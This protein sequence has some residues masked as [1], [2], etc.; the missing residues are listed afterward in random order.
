M[1]NDK[2]FYRLLSKHMHDV[3][4]Y[5]YNCKIIMKQLGKCAPNSAVC[6]GFVLLRKSKQKASSSEHVLEVPLKVKEAP[7]VFLL[8]PSDFQ[9]QCHLMIQDGWSSCHS[10]HVTVSKA[11]KIEEK[12]ERRGALLFFKN[13]SRENLIWHSCLYLTFCQ[14][15]VHGHK[16]QRSLGKC[17]N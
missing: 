16:L 7:P 6:Q 14:N 3:P 5:K 10:T 15:L 12:E 2:K 4:D 13:P 8:H 1:V 9:P 11:K 17:L